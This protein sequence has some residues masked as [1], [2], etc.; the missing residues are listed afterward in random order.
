MVVSTLPKGVLPQLNNLVCPRLIT[1]TKGILRDLLL[2]LKA[3][4]EWSCRAD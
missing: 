3:V 4:V 2:F 1:G